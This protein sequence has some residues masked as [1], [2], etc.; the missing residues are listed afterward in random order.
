MLSGTWLSTKSKS[1]VA[2]PIPGLVILFCKKGGRILRHLVPGFED[3]RLTVN[4]ETGSDAGG[5]E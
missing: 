2:V 3:F 4:E 1:L 5:E